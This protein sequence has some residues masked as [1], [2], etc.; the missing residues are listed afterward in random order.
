[1]QI[2][3]QKILK[4]K[5][6]SF[7]EANVSALNEP[8]NIDSTMKTDNRKP[9]S[10]KRKVSAPSEWKRSKTKLLRNIGHSHRTF[11]RDTE[12]PEWKIRTLLVLLV[13]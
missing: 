10:R 9:K 3:N 4:I 13:D 7:D 6:S 11:K 5:S 2:L 1:V 8:Q 12:I